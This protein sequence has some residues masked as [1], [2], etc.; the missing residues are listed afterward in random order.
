MA[1]LRISLSPRPWYKND[2][3]RLVYKVILGPGRDIGL[4]A[5]CDKLQIG[6]HTLLDEIKAAGLSVG[7]HTEKFHACLARAKTKSRLLKKARKAR[8]TRCGG[9]GLDPEVVV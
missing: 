7:T 6:R 5:L 8:C 2:P 3:R 1:S 9:S 4:P